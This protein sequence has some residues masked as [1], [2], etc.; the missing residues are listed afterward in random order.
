MI[1]QKKLHLLG[2]CLA[3][4]ACE[5]PRP[6]N[7]VPL[8]D[9]VSDI[10]SDVTIVDAPSSDAQDAAEMHDA[11]DAWDASDAQDVVPA[12]TCMPAA[13]DFMPRTM[14]SSWSAPWSAC[15]AV[16]DP[17]RYPYFSMSAAASVRV[18]RMGALEAPGG[19]FD[20]TRD[21]SPSEFV[22]V[23]ADAGANTSAEFLFRDTGI[24]TRYQR[25][26]DEHHAVPAGLV[27]DTT[28]QDFCGTAANAMANMDYCVGPI[29]LNPV[30]NASLAAGMA[31][32][33]P[34]RVHAARIQAAY[35]WWL[36]TSVH[37]ESLTCAVASN[38]CD[39]TAGYYAGTA[40]RDDATQYG[41]SRA[42]LALGD[43]GR[44]AHDRIWDGLLAVRCW[45]DLD[46]GRADGGA[47]AP[48]TNE[49]LRE[50]ARTQLDRALTRGMMMIVQARLR[51][52]A[53]TEGDPMRADER[54]AHGAWIGVV[55]PLF[56]NGIERWSRGWWASQRASAPMGVVSRVIAELRAGE[57]I[58]TA[59]AGRAAADLEA[60]FPCP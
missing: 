59:Q 13:T 55:G 46:G 9:A 36:F 19:F 52:F 60:L 34:T 8:Q 10:A 48:A 24:A 32:A 57:L 4:V 31:N 41:L 50:Q 29:S 53:G 40:G 54:R 18:Q 42:L 44:A 45:R 49:M 12:P 47:I 3:I 11:T 5:S 21:P 1:D 25:R 17:N 51:A 27:L 20:P 39:S 23:M 56:A 58:T 16:T 7:D 14:R 15:T 6:T 26:A 43:S 37:K 35:Q 33:Q 22:A 28:Y 2:C 38:D 30:L